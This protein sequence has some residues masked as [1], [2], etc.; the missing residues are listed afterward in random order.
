M[1]CTKMAD[2]AQGKSIIKLFND[3]KSGL[4]GN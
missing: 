3:G 4:E 1:I 2:K